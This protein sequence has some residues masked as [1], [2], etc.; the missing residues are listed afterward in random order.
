MNILVGSVISRY[1]CVPGSVLNRLNFIAGLQRL[2]HEVYFVE[3]IGADACVDAKGEPCRYEKSA[4]RTL[5]LDLMTQFGLSE[6]ACQVFGGGEQTAGLTLKELLNDTKDALL[7]NMSGH[8]TLEAILENTLAPRLYRSRPRLHTVV[9]L[10][11]RRGLKLWRARC[12][13]LRRLEYRY[14]A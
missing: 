3:E 5:F 12:V 1:P 7:I 2:G 9:A 4:N 11:I 6:R 13:L 10:R 14:R 8:V